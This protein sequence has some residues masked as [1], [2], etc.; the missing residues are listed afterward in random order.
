[1]V[2]NVVQQRVCAVEFFFPICAAN[3]FLEIMSVV[4]LDDDHFTDV[5][6]TLLQCGFCF[7]G[8]EAAVG[9]RKTCG[10]NSVLEI[11]VSESEE[12]PCLI[13]SW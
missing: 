8:C 5:L 13:V 7:V 10:F 4:V 11:E 3:S 6:G 2:L 12:C 9:A 1:V